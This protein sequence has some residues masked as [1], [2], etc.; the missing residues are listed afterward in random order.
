MTSLLDI[1]AANHHQKQSGTRNNYSSL[2]AKLVSVSYGALAKNCGLCTNYYI[3]RQLEYELQQEVLEEGGTTS[4]IA[5]GG[6]DRSIEIMEIQSVQ[7]LLFDEES[8]VESLCTRGT[9][10]TTTTIEEER[11]R[12]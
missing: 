9:T 6:G 10:A 11:E 8:V 5:G 12:F 7:S 4:S 1:E 2:T 3:D